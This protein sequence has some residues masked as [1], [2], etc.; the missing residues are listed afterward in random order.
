[1]QRVGI[2]AIKASAVFYSGSRFECPVCNHRFRKLLPYG[3]VNM[4]ENALCPSCLSLERHRMLWLFLKEQT[5]FFT[6]PLK[7]LHF[8]PEPC[9]LKRIE[10]LGNIDYVTADYESPLAKVK[11]D[12]QNIPFED[13]MFDV[14]FCSHI[15][16]HIENDRLAMSEMFRV[17][18]PGGW[19]IMMCPVEHDRAATYEDVSITNPI[20]R[21]KHFGQK[22]HFRIYGRD[23]ARRLSE[24][25]FK[26][27]EVRY[28]AEVAPELCERYALP[29]NETIYWVKK[30][31]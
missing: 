14:I 25:G 28:G 17:I 26:V 19:G 3:Y 22:D 10:K 16:E 5:D 23:F 7:V 9:F 15:L 11:L 8:A 2:A 29:L 1:M 6:S 4:R 31:L 20:E 30:E 21:E 13:N 24:A 27:N 18:K 12:I